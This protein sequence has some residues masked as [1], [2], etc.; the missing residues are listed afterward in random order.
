M[1]SQERDTAVLTASRGWLD[2][3]PGKGESS[4][5]GVLCLPEMT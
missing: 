2:N 3:V 5:D 1:T 4:A